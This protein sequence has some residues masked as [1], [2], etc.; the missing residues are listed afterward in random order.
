MTS[1]YLVTKT[2]IDP[3]HHPTIP[4][5]HLEPAKKATHIVAS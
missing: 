1:M 3:V 5:F 4:L 2:Y